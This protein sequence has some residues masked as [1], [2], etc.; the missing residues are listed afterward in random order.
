MCFF[1]FFF[2]Q[3]TAYEM[4][5]GLVGSE[6]CIRDRVST[7]STWEYQDRENMA[8][9]IGGKS[10]KWT[11]SRMHVPAPGIP[12][13]TVKEK[14]FSQDYVEPPQ[15]N[16]KRHFEKGESM[17]TD[18][19]SSIKIIKQHFENNEEKSGV[20]KISAQYAPIKPR[21]QRQHFEEKPSGHVD[22]FLGGLKPIPEGHRCTENEHT[23]DRDMGVKHPI[24]GLLPKRNDLDFRSLGDK[25]YK[26]SEDSSDFF[27]GGGLIAGSTHPSKMEKK[28]T[29]NAKIVNYYANLDLTKPV[30]T[31]GLKWT[32]RLKLEEKSED[33]KAVDGLIEWEKTV[34]KDVDPNYVDPD[35]DDDD[36]L[37][38]PEQ[39]KEEKKGKQ[40]FIP[41]TLSLNC[42]LYTSPSPRDL[43]TSRMPS[44]A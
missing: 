32:D 18:Y 13:E 27:K 43:S 19:R 4:Q 7:Q 15:N 33:L 24:Q 34:L 41:I 30:P 8:E 23:I 21:A 37:P 11:T 5:R 36:N 26:F 28:I 14:I 22:P 42:L 29:G 12:G 3:K 16:G 25:S 6:M 38:P 44:S 35:E 40:L 10:Q 20:K 9:W 17:P 1:F 2:K 31:R 39:K